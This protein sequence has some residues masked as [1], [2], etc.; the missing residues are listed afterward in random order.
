MPR[1]WPPLTATEIGRCLNALGY[2]RDHDE[3]THQIW[4]HSQ[5]H[6]IVPIDTKWSPIGG[7]LLQHIVK[8]QLGI[9]REAF[10]GAT[11]ATRRKIG[12][13]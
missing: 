11:K 3:S 4:V 9:S 13:R 8:E 10:Y 7:H 5:T 12:L 6:R 1:G 2:V